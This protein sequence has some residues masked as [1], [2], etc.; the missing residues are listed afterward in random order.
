[1][2]QD[3]AFYRV[4]PQA[5]EIE[6]SI[7]ALCML[8]QKESVDVYD[9][10]I[11]D[12]FY[13]SA[14]QKIFTAM[15]K[16][17][18]EKKEVDLLTVTTTLRDAG[19][20]EEIGGAT[21]LAQV[22][23]DPIPSNAE[24]YINIIK[25]KYTLRR[26]IEETNTIM[27]KCF[28][29]VDDVTTL[30]ND[31]QSAMIGIEHGHRSIQSTPMREVVIDG[32]ERY[33]ELSHT[34]E[35]NGISSG[36]LDIDS[37]TYGFQNSD[38]IVL[39]ARPSMGKTALMLN[40]AMNQGQARVPVGVFSLEQ[41][42]AQLADRAFARTSGINGVKFRS[43]NFTVEDW[44]KITD[45]AEEMEGYPI[46][47]DDSAGLH[48]RD[49]A[50][51]S[52]RMVRDHG[53]KIIY[54][55]YLSFIRGDHQQNKVQEIGSITRGL[56]ALAKELNIPIV[57]LAQLNRKL[58]ERP[59]KRPRLADLRESGDI[60]QDADVVIFIYRDEV[61]NE[62]EDGSN[63]GVAEIIFAKQ[64]NGPVGTVQLYYAAKQMNFVNMTQREV[65]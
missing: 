47:Y 8:F 43:G 3:P 4:P 44:V 27:R 58:E 42:K 63:K 50:R 39:A 57:V 56:K 24:D 54:I 48:Y 60:E 13:R 11:P 33:E 35:M 16:L 25:D 10:L 37:K 29:P 17:N 9:A 19:K 30:L 36:Y 65:V 64:R 59:N 61:Y 62:T 55:D 46:W 18:R 31:S 53:I 1:M 28:E 40:W 34:G 26:M 45:A 41:A 49:I 20:L 14:H 2:N 6:T 5:L 21:Y 38:L 12:E 52:R 7:L 22:C 15:L 32:I 23:D 51:R